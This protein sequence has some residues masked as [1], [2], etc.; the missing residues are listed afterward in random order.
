M[1]EVN[2][3]VEFII[4]YLRGIKIEGRIELRGRRGRRRMQ[5]REGEDTGN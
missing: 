4:R 3:T 1:C 2:C 5:L